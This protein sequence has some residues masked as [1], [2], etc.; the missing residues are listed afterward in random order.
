MCTPKSPPPPAPLP[1]PRQMAKA[2][3]RAGIEARTRQRITAGTSQRQTLVNVDGVVRQA[4]TA[5]LG[6]G[7]VVLGG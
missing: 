7:P 6:G 1:P 2:P 5:T 3:N 4:P